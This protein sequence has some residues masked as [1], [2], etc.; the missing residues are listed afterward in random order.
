SDN[1]SFL[2]VLRTPPHWLELTIVGR[3]PT[4]DRL[5]QRLH[6]VRR[7]LATKRDTRE[8]LAYLRF[9]VNRRIRCIP[10][11]VAGVYDRMCRADI[12]IIP[13]DPQDNLEGWNLKS[14]NRLTMKMCVGLPV[15]A[16]PIPSYERVIEQGRNG[17]LARTEHDWLACL[18]ALRD[19]ALRRDMG[20]TARQTVIKRYSK[21]EQ[22]RLLI[23]V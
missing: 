22:A 6:E 12:G 16:T 7:T 14:E 15:I 18:D 23:E 4:A 21:N 8:R 3:Y 10:W 19:P 2:P 17:F 11:D 9:L 20:G 5:I 13:I 1:L